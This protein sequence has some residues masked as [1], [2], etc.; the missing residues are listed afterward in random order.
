MEVETLEPQQPRKVQTVYIK[1]LNEKVKPDGKERGD[2]RNEG[3]SVSLLLELRAHSRHLHQAEHQDAGAGLRVFP[4]RA[5]CRA[6]DR[7]TERIRA[8][9]ERSGKYYLK[10]IARSLPS[11]PISLERT[12]TWWPSAREPSTRVCGR[13][14][15]KSENGKSNTTERSTARSRRTDRT[16]SWARCRCSSQERASRWPL[17]S[18]CSQSRK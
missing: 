7:G 15:A 11:M 12:Q 18:L 10:G 13:S 14:D 2:V 4:G 17:S 1:N 9:G 3:G 5:E 6:G 8:D 16:P